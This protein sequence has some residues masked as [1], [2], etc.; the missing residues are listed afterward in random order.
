MTVLQKVK[1]EFSEVLK[2]ESGY[3]RD[4][5]LSE[6]MDELHREYRIPLLMDW[7]P[8][9]IE[10]EPGRNEIFNLYRM[11]ADSREL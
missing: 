5:K 2:M 7:I 10:E 8:A 11:I 6:L 1:M 9:W 3:D 4:Q